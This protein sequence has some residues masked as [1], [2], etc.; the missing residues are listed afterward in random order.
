MRTRQPS[1]VLLFVLLTLTGAGCRDG[2]AAAAAQ[3]PAAPA[4]PLPNKD[5]SF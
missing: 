5:G 1:S 3:A 4:V 2:G